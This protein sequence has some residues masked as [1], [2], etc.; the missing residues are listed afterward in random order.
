MTLI[1]SEVLIN[2][3]QHSNPTLERLELVDCGTGYNSNSMKQ[4]FDKCSHL[5]ELIWCDNKL[6]VSATQLVDILCAT[7]H[8]ALTHIDVKLNS[9]VLNCPQLLTI[10]RANPQILQFEAF[11]EQHYM[12]TEN[13]RTFYLARHFLYHKYSYKM[14]LVGNLID[15]QVIK[16]EKLDSYFQFT[17][18]HSSLIFKAI[19][20]NCLI[21]NIV[22]KALEIFAATQTGETVKV[23]DLY[24]QGIVMFFYYLV[25]VP[26]SFEVRGAKYDF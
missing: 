25:V 17:N 22:I 23:F 4:I 2:I 5:T 7:S 26:N 21:T 8:I 9:A 20:A 16:I 18:I 3:A 1:T 13:I 11:T 19:F 14:H 10:L 6:A 24:T 12:N 15:T